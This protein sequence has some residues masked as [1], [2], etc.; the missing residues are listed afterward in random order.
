MRAPQALA[1]PDLPG[2]LC[3]K[4]RWMRDRG[5]EGWPG[6]CTS[7]EGLVAL[8]GTLSGGPASCTCLRSSAGSSVS[9]E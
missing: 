8:S 4:G 2:V 3:Q 1:T 9:C 6:R 7:V 5:Q